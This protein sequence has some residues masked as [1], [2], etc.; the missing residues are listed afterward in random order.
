MQL[1]EILSSYSKNVVMYGAVVLLIL[2]VISLTIKKLTSFLK[3][4]LFISILSVVLFVTLF[5]AGSTIY[6]NV[7][8]FSQGPVHYHADFEI[9]N[10]GQEIDLKD[11]R[12][13]SN[14]I[15]TPTFHEHND[16]RIHLEGVVVDSLSGSLGG[17]FEVAGGYI[18]STSLSILTNNGPLRLRSDYMCQ[19]GAIGQLQVFVYKVQNGAYYQQKIEDPANYIISPE[20]NVPPGDCIIIEFDSFKNKTDKLCKSYKVA[21]ISGKIEEKKYGN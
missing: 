2:V 3:K 15:G 11:P 1:D 13:L 7:S 20:T 19:N 9:W 10:C 6:L 5:L 17:F 21:Q 4:I 12:G 18:T 8:S 16:K 14:K